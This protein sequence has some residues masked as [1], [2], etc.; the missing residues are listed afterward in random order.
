MRIDILTIFPNMFSPFDES[1]IKRAR[2][3]NILDINIHDIREFSLEKHKNVD[4]YPFGGGAGM[5]MMVEPIVLAIEYVRKINS[6]KVI[7]L[8]PR[9]K[10]FNQNMA[11]EYSLQKELI[12]V[13]GHYEGVDERVFE[14]IDEE[15]SLGDFILTG[16][17]MAAI[18]II[19]SISRLIPGVLSSSESL[20]EES[21]SG[22]LLEY[23]QYTRPRD[24]R[25]LSVPEV[26][27]SGH[28]LNIKK[29]RQS[30]S[31]RITEKYRPDLKNKN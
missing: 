13:C 20:S 26:L 9:G 17:E 22:D 18:P 21:F 2:D 3:N 23:P 14:F 24:F 4:D 30:E 5:I 12:F 29:W 27:L 15:I 1:I 6:G 28:H 25:G 8:G 31:M 19:D 7:F 10:T 16:G 11:K